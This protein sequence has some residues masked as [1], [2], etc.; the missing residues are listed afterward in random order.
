MKKILISLSFITLTISLY[1]KGAVDIDKKT[2]L[3]S[4]D[5]V[6]LFYLVAK[7]TQLFT[8]DYSLENLDH[9]ELAYL[10]RIET[11]VYRNGS[12]ANDVSYQMVFGKT[13]NSCYINDGFG[14]FVSAS[15]NLARVIHGAGLVHDNAISFESERKF[16]LLHNGLFMNDPR[17]NGDQAPIKVTSIEAPKIPIKTADIFIKESK[18]YNHSELVGLY[19]MNSENGLDVVKV[20]NSMDVMVCTATHATGNN[21]DDWHLKMEDKQST[22]LYSPNDALEKL[23]K[24]LAEQGAL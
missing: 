11:P 13:G 4:S 8:S 2:G 17:N 7:N 9:Q 23:F 3:V 10:K 5:G 15:K 1:A 18:I 19:K 12:R 14:T 16:V 6:S 20:Y 22:I 24:Y 21:N